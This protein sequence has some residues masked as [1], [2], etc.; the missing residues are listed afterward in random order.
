MP[1]K[2]QN[3]ESISQ[4]KR[5][6][7]WSSL[8]FCFLIAGIFRSHSQTE[9]SPCTRFKRLSLP[10]KCWVILHPFIAEK[11]WRISE[12]TKEIANKINDTLLDGDAAG[13]Q[14]DAFR[15]AFWMASL[16][17]EIN[18]IRA[19]CLGKA[20]EMGN[21]IEFKQ[22]KPEDGFLPDKASTEMDL[23]NNK[24]GI[25]IGQKNKKISE[26][27]LIL[28]IKNSIL[29]GE[30]RVIKKDSLGNSLNEA[31]EIIEEKDWNGKW[32]NQRVLV[33]SDVRRNIAR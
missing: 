22:G 1:D 7:Y 30:L 3:R 32:Q 9:Q 14:S 15:H 6:K 26:E 31:G 17:Q 18:W 11:T 2:I 21:Y 12:H 25:L 4:I 23:F 20:H 5:W 16:C 19:Y 10:E 28:L 29:N 8:A 27:Q 33:R 13:G 24:Y